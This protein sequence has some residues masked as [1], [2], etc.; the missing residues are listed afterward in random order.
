[1]AKTDKKADAPE[2]TLEQQLA[3]FQ[4]FMEAQKKE[5]D[6]LKKQLELA[7]GNKA[8]EPKELPK[9]PED[10]FEVEGEKYQFNVARF[11][12]MYQAKPIDITAKDALAEPGILSELVRLGSGLIKK[13]A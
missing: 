7:T 1:M 11:A 3:G 12:M 10:I 4:E 2:T 9:V 5:N 13:V 8:S 6:A